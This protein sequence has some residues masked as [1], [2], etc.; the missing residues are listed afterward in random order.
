MSDV[1][2]S[3]FRTAFLFIAGSAALQ[4]TPV[5]PVNDFVDPSEVKSLI[6]SKGYFKGSSNSWNHGLDSVID[7][8][9]TLSALGALVGHLSRVMV[10]T[11]ACLCNREKGVI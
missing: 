11:M 3:E 5:Q 2:D 1:G 8:E 4:L 6:Q 10:S 7:H 9:I